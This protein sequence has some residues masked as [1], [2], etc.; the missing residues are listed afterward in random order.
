MIDE[1][2]EKINALL[3][4]RELAVDLYNNIIYLQN[5]GLDNVRLLGV[6]QSLINILNT[7]IYEVEVESNE[8][9]NK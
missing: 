1:K 5:F 6:C 2:E 9:G 4:V 3:D 8:G 7:M